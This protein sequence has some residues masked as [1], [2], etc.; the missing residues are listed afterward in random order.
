MLFEIQ[1]SYSILLCIKIQ[2]YLEN[3][4]IEKSVMLF[5]MLDKLMVEIMNVL[6]E[7]NPYVETV[8]SCRF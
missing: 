4:F 2:S 3:T 6:Y 5:I 7:I 1:Q 8:I